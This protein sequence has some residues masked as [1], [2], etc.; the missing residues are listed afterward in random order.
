MKKGH[1]WAIERE[2][3]VRPEVHRP[4]KATPGMTCIPHRERRGIAL[5]AD[6]VIGGAPMCLA[7]FRGRP[8]DPLEERGEA[9]SH[10]PR[11]RRGQRRVITQEE[12]VRPHPGNF[13]RL[14]RP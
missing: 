13:A 14:R 2:P 12:G 5:P 9:R 10:R 8:I 1:K 3:E 7:C 4:M 11:A 6:I